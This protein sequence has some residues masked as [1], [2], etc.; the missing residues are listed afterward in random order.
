MERERENNHFSSKNVRD[1]NKKLGKLRFWSLSYIPY[2]NL[3]PNLSVVS[4]WSLTF[5]Y[6]INSVSTIIFWMK[7]DDVSNG[8]N[9]KLASIEVRIN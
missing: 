1:N 5:E 7:I 8:Q 4:I 6:Y 9:K 3:I 2:F